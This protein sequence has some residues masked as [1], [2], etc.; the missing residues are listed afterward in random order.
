[1]QPNL[2]RTKPGWR[3]ATPAD[4]TAPAEPERSL[5]Q[6]AEGKPLGER[7]AYWLGVHLGNCYGLNKVSFPERVAWV[8]QHGQEIMSFAMAPLRPHRFWDEADKRWM[9]FMKSGNRSP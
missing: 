6:F 7:G 4:R 9:L 5:V 1:M 3:Q 2:P 8:H